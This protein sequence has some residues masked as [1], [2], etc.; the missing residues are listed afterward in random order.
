MGAMI[1]GGGWS[2]AGEGLKSAGQSI[3]QYYKMKIDEQDRQDRLKQ[4]ATQNALREKTLAAE[5]KRAEMEA[6]RFEMQAQNE[7]Y[8]RLS[9]TFSRLPENATIS[10]QLGERANAVGLGAF[11]SPETETPITEYGESLP[12]EEGA[13]AEALRQALAQPGA[14]PGVQLGETVPTGS[15][16]VKWGLNPAE[17]IKI[18]DAMSDEQYRKFMMDNTRA[19]NARASA[20]AA[21]SRAHRDLAEEDAFNR[22]A[23][24]LLD[25]ARRSGL[26]TWRSQYASSNGGDAAVA[27]LLGQGLANDRGKSIGAL[28]DHVRKALSAQVQALRPGSRLQMFYTPERIEAILED[29]TYQAVEDAR[30]R[31]SLT[32]RT[33]AGVVDPGTTGTGK[34]RGFADRLKDSLL[35]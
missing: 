11:L 2:A 12:G 30:D 20:A 18:G 13:Q 15:Y 7:E 31:E 4:E 10:G 9:D 5:A 28:K 35:K 23:Q 34:P 14:V 3:L 8:D 27:A 29:L 16:N 33:G 21:D 22:G 19:D 24:G 1:S 26:A 25:Q 32:G 17:R 6:K